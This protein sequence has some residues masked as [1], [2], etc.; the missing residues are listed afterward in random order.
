MISL[1]DIQDRIENELKQIELVQEQAQQILQQMKP[2]K[3]NMSAVRGWRLNIH[4][5]VERLQQDA[6]RGLDEDTYNS[7][8]QAQSRLNGLLDDF[9]MTLTRNADLSRFDVTF[10]AY[11]AEE[12]RIIKAKGFSDQ[13]A[14]YDEIKEIAR[15]VDVQLGIANNFRDEFKKREA[16][17]DEDKRAKLISDTRND[18]KK[19]QVDHL[20]TVHDYVKTHEIGMIPLEESAVRA[21]VK[22]IINIFWNDKLDQFEDDEL[23]TSKF[24]QE[25]RRNLAYRLGEDSAEMVIHAGNPIGNEL[26]SVNTIPAG[27]MSKM[28]QLAMQAAEANGRRSYATKSIP[29]EPVKLSV[30]ARLSAPNRNNGESTVIPE[31]VVERLT[32]LSKG[33]YQNTLD[34]A[35]EINEYAEKY[36]TLA[37]TTVDEK[38]DSQELDELLARITVLEAFVNSFNQKHNSA[39]GRTI[40]SNLRS[41]VERL[42]Q[43]SHNQYVSLK[44]ALNSFEDASDGL[45]QWLSS[46]FYQFGGQP[47]NHKGAGAADKSQVTYLKVRKSKA[48]VNEM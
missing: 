16:S 1:V 42:R 43:S 21:G 46:S 40:T 37:L 33:A 2:H 48:N 39:K 10:E 32:E 23:D 4:R 31:N 47:E 26:E 22:R 45:K 25:A 17:V 11:M 3:E 28:R 24:V 44:N 18:I 8:K 20:V 38:L 27:I 12:R 30:S 36:G 14:W 29:T 13:E 35:D 15:Q 9:S 7:L 5:N 19:Y 6:E 34:N 41:A